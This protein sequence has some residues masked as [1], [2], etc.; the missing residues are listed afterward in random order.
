M[1][2]GGQEGLETSLQLASGLL[3]LR[4]LWDKL[5][6]GNNGPATQDSP[7]AC[8]RARERLPLAL[9]ARP[10][11]CWHRC[12]AEHRLQCPRPVLHAPPQ[13]AAAPHPAQAGGPMLPALP[14]PSAG[15]AS[16]LCHTVCPPAL[17]LVVATGD[18]L[19]LSGPCSWR[20]TLSIPDPREA[21]GVRMP[22]PCSSAPHLLTSELS[23]FLQE[24][25]AF[26]GK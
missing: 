9:P 4:L 15:R 2:G 3:A 23:W 8:P 6:L 10:G 25:S 11:A 7:C 17:L 5:N 22:F 20:R 26:V 18:Q 16:P 14:T 19:I 12:H 24:S 13:A 1:A 21:G